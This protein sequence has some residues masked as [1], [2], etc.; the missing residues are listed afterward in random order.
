MKGGWKQDTNG[1][2]QLDDGG[3][4][5]FSNGRLQVSENETA[6]TAVKDGCFYGMEKRTCLIADWSQTRMGSSGRIMVW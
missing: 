2:I 1:L 4:Y 3:W 6:K 5:Q